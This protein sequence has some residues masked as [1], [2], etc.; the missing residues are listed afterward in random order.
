MR[1]GD[2][3][4]ASGVSPR[5]LRFYEEQG[6][7]V[8][9]RFGNGYRDFCRGTIDRAQTVR[10]LLESGV[11]IRLIKIILTDQ[12]DG[13]GGAVDLGRVDDDVVAAVRDHRRRIVERIAA[14]DER[15]T[16]LDT[17]LDEL[18]RRR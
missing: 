10:S 12:P 16:A 8:P 6:L 18:D 2:A 7:I 14:L 11:P 1:I 5:S 4:R 13:T 3:A 9:G 15:R 17:F